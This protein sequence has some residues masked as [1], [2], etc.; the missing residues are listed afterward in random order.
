MILAVKVTQIYQN[1]S[2]WY[3]ERRAADRISFAPYNVLYKSDKRT[4]I[5]LTKSIMFH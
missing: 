3:H 5:I 2:V 4:K 1:I